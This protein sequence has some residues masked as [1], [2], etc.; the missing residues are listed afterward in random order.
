M[1]AY[2]FFPSKIRVPT[3]YKIAN[4]DARVFFRFI[5][6]I[7]GWLYNKDIIL[8]KGSEKK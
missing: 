7:S 6:A 3:A 2:Y 5:D 8:E 1:F 4:S